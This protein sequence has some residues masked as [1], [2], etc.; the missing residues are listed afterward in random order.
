MHTEI[1]EIFHTKNKNF[2]NL[3]T[4]SSLTTATTDG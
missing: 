2:P 3:A 4:R 1:V